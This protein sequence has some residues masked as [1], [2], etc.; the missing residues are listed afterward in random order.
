MK[1]YLIGIDLGG[2]KIEIVVL[3]TNKEIQFRERLPTESRKGPSHIINQ[4]KALYK[5]A[6]AFINNAPHTIGVGSPGSLSAKTGLLRNSNTLCLNELPL[7]KLIEEALQKKIVLEND[8]N[9]FALAEAN[10]GAGKN[11]NLVFGVIMGTGCGGGFVINNNL[12]VGPQ[13]ISGEWGHSVIN[14]EGPPSYCGNKGCVEAY[15]SGG[16]LENIL[17]SHGL[18]SLTA[19]DFLNKKI[20]TDDEKFILKDFY[21]NFGIALANIINIIDPD[22]VVLGG[23]LSNHEALYDIG[24]QETYN[25]VFHESPSTPIVKNKLGDSAGVIGAAIIGD[26]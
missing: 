7:Q 21:S 9:C 16:G 8:A 2:T 18:L 15:I 17:K 11:H 4:I 22:I 12:R 19:K 20:Y 25:R 23:G 24:I 3:D 1:N 6:V 26:I 13:Q 14:S 10:F 5:N